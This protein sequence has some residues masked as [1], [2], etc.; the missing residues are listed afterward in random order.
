[1]PNWL[2]VVIALAVVALLFGHPITRAGITWLLPL[3]SGFDDTI[4]LAA[5]VV[6]LVILVTRGIKHRHEINR[7]FNR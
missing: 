5:I 1:M 7:W 6:A 4:E 3:G 2:K